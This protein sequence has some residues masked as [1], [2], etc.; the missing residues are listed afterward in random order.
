MQKHPVANLAFGILAVITMVASLCTAAL[1]S[2]APVSNSYSLTFAEALRRLHSHPLLMASR[3]RIA[4]AEAENQA[5]RAL[6]LPRLGIEGTYARLSDPIEVD[7]APLNRLIESLDPALPSIPNPILQG[8]SFGVVMA[9]LA[10]PVFTG[11]RI[12]AAKKA[13][14]AGITGAVAAADTTSDTLLLDLVTRYYGVAVNERALAVQTEVVSSLTDH[15]A[16]AEALEREGQIASVERMQ[17][18]VALAQAQVAEQ[19]RRHAL[20]ISRAGLANLIGLNIQGWSTSAGPALAIP[21]PQELQTLQEVARQSN[22]V[23]QQLTA[24][25]AQADQAIRAAR[26]A[27]W[28]DVTLLGGYELESDLLPELLPQWTISLNL[29][30]NLFDG[31]ATRAG[32]SMAREH[33]RE[34]Q[35]LQRDAIERLHLQVESRYLALE[36]ARRRL[37]VTMRTESLAQETLRMQRLAFAAGMGRSIDVLDAQSAVAATRLQQL[38][39]QFDNVLAWTA[40]MLACGHRDQVE[41]FL[42]HAGGR[43]NGK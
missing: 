35:S 14:A 42:S 40:L 41:H 15:L 12:D 19:E 37:A 33:L 18:E 21:E 7:L 1:T 31:G 9:T 24:I 43:A 28:P 11:G 2:A 26:S 32:V 3:A 27:Y 39:A 30:M 22:P 10:W 29:T 4:S 5:A 34:A 20:Q 17:V 13:T 6:A 36:D 8:D 23:I 16:N 38:A 25:T